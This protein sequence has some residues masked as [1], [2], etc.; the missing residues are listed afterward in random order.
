MLKTSYIK[1]KE[2]IILFSIIII[3]AFIRFASIS[4]NSLWTDEIATIQY[5]TGTIYNIAFGY[6]MNGEFNPPLFYL[7]ESIM[8]T[9]GGVS[10]F[11]L[12]F[13]PSIFGLLT[14]PIVYLISKELTKNKNLSYLNTFIF[15]I[16][17]FNIYYSI[18]ARCY[19]LALLLFT[20][21]FYYYT[22]EDYKK[23]FIFF[24]LLTWTHFF[25]FIFILPLLIHYLMTKRSAKLPVLY[26]LGIA[27]LL[28]PLYN[29]LLL[30]S[31]SDVGWGLNWSEIL[32][33][34]F[35][36]IGG[37][38][39]ISGVILFLLFFSGLLLYK[40]TQIKLMFLLPLVITPLLTF[41]LNIS[42]RYLIYFIPFYIIM[43]TYPL[44]HIKTKKFN[45]K[46]IYTILIIFLFI[47]GCYAACDEN[48]IDYCS[49]AQYL[50][51]NSLNETQI[52]I[53]PI[54]RE[55]CLTHYYKGDMT[56]LSF[57]PYDLDSLK[58]NISKNTWIV[59]T[60]VAEYTN[61]ND[62]VSNYLNKN[63]TKIKEFN[64][65]SIYKYNSV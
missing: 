31:S 49:S 42:T 7:F 32:I 30:K 26:A 16:L 38:N 36:E 15:T 63:C 9:L 1:S 11:T 65:I 45:E 17:P 3:G 10:E 40:N 57:A 37:M 22:K 33:Q 28:I 13:L 62:A 14:I 52:I 27:P 24:I 23:S 20:V 43:I 47:P 51:N 2:F 48:K 12:R 41:F 58:N 60:G 25:G 46:Q 21:G 55:G 6:M 39:I 56:V 59:K 18:E 8:I 50:E 44:L 5:S 29:M 35:T 54:T 19:T 4:V 34:Y 61:G 64:L 53:M